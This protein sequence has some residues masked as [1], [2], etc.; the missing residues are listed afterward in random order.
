MDTEQIIADLNRRFAAPLPEFYQRR[1]I[2]WHDEEKEFV[3]EIDEMRLDNAK[4]AV[5]TGTN[6]FAVKK[7]LVADDADSNYLLYS[8]FAYETPED[9]W[10]LDI[11]LYSEEFRADLISMWL[12]EMGLPQIPTLR[13][14]IKPYRKFMNAKERRRKIMAQTNLPTTAGGLQLAI[15][16]ALAGMKDA[17]PVSIIKA[18]L[19]GGLDHAHNHLWQDFETYHL[20]DVFWRMAAQGTGYDEEDPTLGALAVHIMLTAAARTIRQDC[21]KGLDTHISTAH[22]AFCY[23]FV[24]DWLYAEDHHSLHEIAEFV[25]LEAHLH[26]RFMKLEIAD[27]LNTAMFPCVNEIILVKLMRDMEKNNPSPK[28][29]KETVEKRRTL[30]WYETSRHFYEGLYQAANMREF[31]YAHAD[32]FHTIEPKKIWQEYTEEYYRFDTFYRRFHQSY[33]AS[34]KTYHADLSDLFT[35]IKDMVEGL[36]VNWFL[37]ELGTS[38]SNAVEESL[39]KHGKVFDVPMQ[40]EFYRHKVYPA[41]SR[42]YVIIS[43]ALRYEVAAELTDDLRR[44]TQS[45]VELGSM[46]GI[47][48]TITKFGMAALLPHKRL[49]VEEK[50]GR[51]SVLADGESTEAPRR[52]KILKAA[53]PK[54]VAL[55]YKDMLGMKR[56]ERSALVRGMDVVYIY[57]DTIDEAGHSE[58]SIFG[59]CGEAIE[60]IKNMVRIITGEFSGTRILITADHGFLYT[61]HPLREDDKVDKITKSSQDVDIARRYAIVRKGAAPEYLLPVKFLDGDT[62]YDAFAPRGNLRIKMKGGGLN[63][64]H[65]GISLQELVVPLIE[66][67]Y[68]RNDSK[69]YKKNKARYDTKPVTLSLLSSSRKI[70][71]MMFSLTF[72]Q[73]EAVAGN[74]QAAVYALYFTDSNGKAVSDTVRLIADKTSDHAEERTFRVGF[75]LKSLKY[76]SKENYYLVIADKEGLSLSREEFSIDI[77]DA[78]TEFDF[79]S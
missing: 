31:Y 59:A 38:W 62:E 4:V 32:G 33:D 66:Y 42:V 26:E 14:A 7:L 65:G 1:I 53:N 77:V 45:K 51:L 20:A 21:L 13:S 71:N 54:S 29:V 44:E 68:L 58:S 15:M 10:L 57:H 27:L 69:E 76:D 25:E 74:F 52:D 8:P 16:A 36:Y 3:D 17:K 64:V 56:P 5:L 9:N 55:K 72:Y 23:D 73:K 40:T 50:A 46:Q 79:F 70:S 2:V 19:K 35:D 41:D 63:F 39:S 47:F 22:V 61:F 49:S 78:V 34:L 67:R 43:D 37:E 30:A 24:S 11:E 75:H 18:V 48:P 60:E 28:A 6:Y 12:S